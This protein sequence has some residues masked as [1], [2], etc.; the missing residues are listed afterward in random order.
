MSFTLEMQPTRGDNYR[1]IAILIGM[2]FWGFFPQVLF[3]ISC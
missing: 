1:L 3:D 2:N